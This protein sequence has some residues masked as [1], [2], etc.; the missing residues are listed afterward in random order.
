VATQVVEN[1]PETSG[2]VLEA[3][4]RGVLVTLTR[5]RK[6]HKKTDPIKVGDIEVMANDA[7]KKNCWLMGRIGSTFTSPDGQVYRSRKRE[8][9]GPRISKSREQYL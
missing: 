4:G 5:R 1:R 9:A 2:H 8:N 6:W 3:V 7:L